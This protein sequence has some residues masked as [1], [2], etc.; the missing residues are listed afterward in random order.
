MKR[1]TMHTENP[2]TW[3][4]VFIYAI[5]N[6]NERNSESTVNICAE[7]LDLKGAVHSNCKSTTQG[8]GL[9]IIYVKMIGSMLAEFDIWQSMAWIRR[10]EH[11]KVSAG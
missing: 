6:L 8:R 11:V 5:E 9:P 10:T 4:S 2:P 1:D 7:Q 3:T